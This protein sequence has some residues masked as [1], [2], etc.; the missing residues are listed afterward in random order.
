[1]HRVAVGEDSII[2]TVLGVLFL[3][4]FALAI[5]V[6]FLY[7]VIISLKSPSEMGNG[8]LVPEA[9]VDLLRLRHREIVLLRAELSDEQLASLNTAPGAPF[10]PVLA[11]PPPM[12][13]DMLVPTVPRE[14][15]WARRVALEK[16]SA[17]A[18]H[19]VALLELRDPEKKLRRVDRFA[20]LCP[21][22][23]GNAWQAVEVSRV[24]HNFKTL[25]GRLFIN[26][27]A[28][29]R[30]D[31]LA[32]GR[33]LDWLS[34]GYPRWYLNSLFVA[35]ATVLLGI[36]FDSLAAFAFAK[37][38]FPLRR[39]LFAVLVATL[40]IPYP[41]TLVPSFFIF[42]KLGLYNTYAALIIPGLVSAFGIFL[43]RQ[44]IQTIPN[45]LVAA[46][47]ADGA[48]DFEVYRFVILPTARPVLAALAV[49]RFLWQ[50]NSYLYPLILT[51]RDSMK[52]LQLGLATLQEAFGTLDY[53]LQMAGATLAV[54]PILLI[55]LV[56]QRHFIAGITMGSVKG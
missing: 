48:S 3:T 36:F 39:P 9:L 19:V 51:N 32:Q 4:L 35:A 31:V 44:Y 49:F 25:L 27:R 42:A 30:W 34:H 2:R 16:P 23:S 56:M 38:D 8:R 46:A 1:M 29:V 43:V 18:H 52:T 17:A 20:L 33:F 47:R 53:G 7:M 10:V 37:F 5:V 22:P 21:H 11:S 15:L 40:M 26:Y 55:Y 14:T 50:W 13:K 12:L 6:P 41:V 45:D 54:I 28:L 24:P